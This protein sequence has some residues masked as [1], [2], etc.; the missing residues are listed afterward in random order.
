M[1]KINLMFTMLAI[2]FVALSFTAC[3]SD[4]DDNA[5][6]GGSST[7]Y[8]E[9]NFNGK[10][11]REKIYEEVLAQIDN[12]G[13]DEQG[14]KLSFTYDMQAH[15]DN[16]GFNFMFGIVHYRNKSELLNSIPGSYPC[17]KDI[18]DDNFDNNLAFI[19]LLKIDGD[20]YE[21]ISGTHQVKKI[22]SAS[23][24][25]YVEGS[26][27]ATFKRDSDRKTVTGSYKLLIP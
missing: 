16:N 6:G 4:D 14:K 1:K 7:S 24:G 2:I 21:F 9:V 18:V 10:T 25:V 12:S 15:F 5:S 22:S 17:A 23:D 19:P 8:I 26:F 27:T 20:E 3:G 11:Y 13:V